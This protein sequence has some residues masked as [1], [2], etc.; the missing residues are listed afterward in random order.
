MKLTGG[1][2]HEVPSSS[3]G[4]VRVRNLDLEGARLAS[5]EPAAFRDAWADER[6]ASGGSELTLRLEAYAIASVRLDD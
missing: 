3:P 6:L 5:R 1:P 4:E 2:S